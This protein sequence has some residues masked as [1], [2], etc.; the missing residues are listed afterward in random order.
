MAMTRRMFGTGLVASLAALLTGAW[1][2]GYKSA[3]A[4]VAAVLRRGGF[5]GTL[6]PM[7]ENEVRR[8]AE[9]RG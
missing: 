6:R 7:D 9:W 5:P 4:R 2:V 3:R 8:P 1:R